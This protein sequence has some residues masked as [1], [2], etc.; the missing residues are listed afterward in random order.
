MVKPRFSVKDFTNGKDRTSLDIRE[1]VKKAL[2]QHKDTIN[3][4]EKYDKGEVPTPPRVAKHPDLRGYLK[5]LRV[6][7]TRW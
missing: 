1:H 5:S 3:F 7:A 6:N 4:L 2:A